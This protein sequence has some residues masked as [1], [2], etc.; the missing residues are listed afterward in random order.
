MK[1]D[2][3]LS[4]RDP[5]AHNTL[6][7]QRRE[8]EARKLRQHVASFPQQKPGISAQPPRSTQPSRWDNPL[9]ANGDILPPPSTAPASG[10]LLHAPL[11]ANPS[12]AVSQNLNQPQPGPLPYS[13]SKEEKA[14][15]FSAPKQTRPSF[16]AA[17]RLSG[18]PE[19]THH[20]LQKH[21]EDSI[22]FLS[23]NQAPQL[24]E[25]LGEAIGNLFGGEP[26][27]GSPINKQLV[28][29]ALHR[30]TR[31]EF[32]AI[33]SKKCIENKYEQISDSLQSSYART[34][35]RFIV[36]NAKTEEDHRRLAAGV[37]LLMDK[38]SVNPKML[39]KV[40]GDKLRPVKPD[41]TTD[42]LTGGQNQPEKSTRGRP[43]PMDGQQ[44]KTNPAAGQILG[45]HKS[46]SS[47]MRGVN[48]HKA[49][50]KGKMEGPEGSKGGRKRSLPADEEHASKKAKRARPATA[51]SAS[52]GAM[53]K[54]FENLLS[55]EAA[56]SSKGGS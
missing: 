48:D 30:A 11:V 44:N 5:I 36:H 26:L 29:K 22:T 18:T 38:E 50:R 35:R 42:V 55:R 16:V 9:I 20:D 43:K 2:F 27:D 3:E 41:H 19:F 52:V 1:K 17:R 6:I 54:T 47:S 34:L 14:A 10:T 49:E 8:E 39:L 46:G 15:S 51:G 12:P 33:I 32:Q 4:R 13:E 23:K 21:I 53:W 56:R 24:E 31:E 25:A 40:L 37:K 28:P 45:H 7:N